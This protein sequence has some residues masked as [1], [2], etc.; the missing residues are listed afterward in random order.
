[1]QKILKRLGYWD[2][3]ITKDLGGNDRVASGCFRP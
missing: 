1:M 3:R 2:I